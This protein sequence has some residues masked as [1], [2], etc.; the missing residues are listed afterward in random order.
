MMEALDHDNLTIVMNDVKHMREEVISLSEH[1]DKKFETLSKEIKN[2]D[3][4]CPS[5]LCEAH[6][7]RIDAVE[8]DIA[9]I[10][11]VGYVA[12]FLIGIVATIFVI[13]IP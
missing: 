11:T 7:K 5:P 2:M 10:K 1:I 12:V 9:R 13:F 3:N 4:R 6:D 8:T